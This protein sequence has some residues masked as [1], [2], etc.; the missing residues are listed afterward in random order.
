MGSLHPTHFE[1]FLCKVKLNCWV[2]TNV[3]FPESFLFNKVQKIY[4]TC[5][6]PVNQT[7]LTICLP[8]TLS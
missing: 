8:I 4:E 3:K 1:R 6:H 2:K 5:H 7:W